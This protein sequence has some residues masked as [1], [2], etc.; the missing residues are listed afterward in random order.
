LALE[1]YCPQCRFKAQAWQIVGPAVDFTR[2]LPDPSHDQFLPQVLPMHEQISKQHFDLVVTLL[3][4]HG[5]GEDIAQVSVQDCL[6]YRGAAEVPQVLDQLAHEHEQRD[7][8]AWEDVCPA[9]G[10]AVITHGA[11]RLPSDSEPLETLWNEVGSDSR[12]VWEEVRDLV[13]EA[14]RWLDALQS[15]SEMS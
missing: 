5:R 15:R 4:R 13:A 7:G 6:P 11:Y 2:V 3:R 1:S 9:Y 10:L 14:W 12:L 8:M